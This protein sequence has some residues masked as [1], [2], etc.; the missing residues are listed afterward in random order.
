MQVESAFGLIRHA[1]QTRRLA[2][3]YLIAG[4]PRGAGGELTTRVL[5][6]LFCQQND[7][8][9]GAC[10]RCRQ[11]RERT[12]AD[13][14]WVQ[15]EKKSRLI[16]AEQMREGL[17]RRISQ[18]SLTGGWKAGVI[19]GADRMGDA[20]ANVFLKTLEEP[21][22]Q[23][24]F[25]LLTDAPQLLLPT[26]LSRC[27]RVEVDD[28]HTL[29][30][31][32]R[33]RLLDVLAAPL[34][35]GPIAAMSMATH[36]AALLGEMKDAAEEEVKA[37]SRAEEQNLDEEKD[38]LA[39]RISA[40]YREMRTGWLREMLYWYRDLLVLR[41]SGAPETLRNPDRAALLMDRAQRLTLGQA[42]ANVQGIE[43]LNRQLDRSLTEESV[44]AYWLDRLAGGVAP[45]AARPAVGNAG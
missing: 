4:A 39:A 24:I 38:V 1:F 15:P 40:R 20:A 22:P 18:T 35:P 12:W 33:T 8:P 10:D 30:E 25:L 36:L 28:P 6:M 26:I 32:W 17:L 41:S 31:P 16:A 19:L 23:S 44:L 13:A 2:H 34:P 5:Q 14:F 43:D 29:P 37:E 21:P 11:V 3:A 7:A 27:Q 42:L 9:C 45:A